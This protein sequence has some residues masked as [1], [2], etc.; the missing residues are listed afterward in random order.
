MT[1]RLTT[2]QSVDEEALG[3]RFETRAR[4]KGGI[5]FTP[6]WLVQQVLEAVA[7]FVPAEGPLAIVDPACGAGAFL[8]AAAEKFPRAKLFGCELES[9]SARE[10]RTRVPGA[11]VVQGDALRGP[12]LG[13]L[14][15]RIPAGAFELWLGNPPYNGR[16]ALLDDP[17]AFARMQK[18]LVPEAELAKGQSL[19]DDFAF[20]LLVATEHLA[21]RE[22]ALA[23]ITS[24]SLLDAY[25]YAPLRHTLLSRLALRGAVDL[26]LGVFRGTKV[27][28]CFTVWTTSREGPVKQAAAPQYRLREVSSEA[29][30][31]HEAWRKDGELL[32]R[33]IPVSLP[34]LKTRFDELLTDADPERLRERLAELMR[35]PKKK[36]AA[37]SARHRIPKACAAK[38]AALPTG[39]TIDPA[40]VRAFIRYRGALSRGPSEFCYLDRALIPRGDHR[41]HGDWDPHQGRCKLIF[42][43][44]ELPLWAELLE[45]AGCVTAYQHT[46]FAPLWVPQ[47]VRDEG[48][49]V[50]NHLPLAEL[51]PLVPNLSP[52]GLKWAEQLG[53]PREVFAEVARFIRSDAVQQIWAP[54]FGAAEELA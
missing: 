47:R 22:G 7:P 38:L 41:L 52:R 27:R 36:L 42:N 3:E 2:T 29:S 6:S 4:R 26:G 48:P 18:L 44:R 25:L 39:L 13:K 8:S 33:L 19:R 14:L 17:H 1:A 34:G 30:A 9:R 16:S 28:T 12:A 21:R 37:F 51:G 5:Y 45:E 10:C 11:G 31:L 32:T 49:E 53:G 35:T 23:F 54:A 15:K 20:F 43:I 46:R 24:A 50:A 40:K